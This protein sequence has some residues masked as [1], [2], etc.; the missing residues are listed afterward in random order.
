MLPDVS[1]VC[2]V[3]SPSCGH[4]AKKRAR[5]SN[6]PHRAPQHRRGSPSP[7]P[8]AICPPSPHTVSKSKVKGRRGG[9]RAT[10]YPQHRY[11][12]YRSRLGGVN[13]AF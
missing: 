11:T 9:R 8:L 3:V 6:S 10:A 7:P 13:T 2:R 12:A 4:D 1:L 5:F